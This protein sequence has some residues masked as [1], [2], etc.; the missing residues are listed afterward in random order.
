MMRG[1]TQEAFFARIR[2]SLKDRGAPVELPSDLEIAR[3]A[4]A[5]GDLVTLFMERAKQVGMHPARVGDDQAA[6]AMVIDIVLGAGGDTAILPEDDVPARALIA[7]GL[8]A[9]GV[10]LLDVNDRDAAF[11]ADFGITGVSCAIAETGSLGVDSG[12]ARRRLASLAV[13]NHIAI[14]RSGQ[15]VADLLDF[16]ACISPGDMPANRT[17]ISAPSKTADIEMIL[18]EGV[19][20]PK[21][22]HVIVIAS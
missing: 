2:D 9:K 14:V 18:V 17:L 16:A 10:R 4:A 12:G 7:D 3:V 1:Q 6:A 20:G 15:I 19:H 21:V 22:V 13:P 8:K 11:D 5:D